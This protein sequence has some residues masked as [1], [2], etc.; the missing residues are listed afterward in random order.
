MSSSA[1][2]VNGHQLLLSHK[3]NQLILRLDDNQIQRSG[4][5]SKG[6]ALVIHKDSLSYLIPPF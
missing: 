5:N 6:I 3:P 2:A 1:N 4:C